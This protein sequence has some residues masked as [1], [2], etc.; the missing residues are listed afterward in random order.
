MFFFPAVLVLSCV[1][2]ASQICLVDRATVRCTIVYP[3]NP[4]ITEKFA[5]EELAKYLSKSTGQ[6]IQLYGENQLPGQLPPHLLVVGRCR[7]ATDAGIDCKS[8][9][10]EEILLVARNGNVYLA[11]GDSSPTANPRWPSEE[12]FGT[13]FSV[14]EFLERFLG[15]RW[16]WP[17]ELGEIV[18]S[19]PTVR[20]PSNLNIR[21]KPCFD[22]RYVYGYYADDPAITREQSSLWWRRQRVGSSKAGSPGTHSFNGWPARF[23]ETR[24]EYFAVG[25]DGTR[26][27]DAE[28]GGGHVCL[29]SDAVK[30]QIIEDALDWFSKGNMN[31]YIWPGDSFDLYGCKCPNCLAMEDKNAPQSGKHSRLVWSLVNEVA[32]EV[33]KVYPDRWIAGGSYATHADIPEGM[34]FEPNVSVTLC[35]GEGIVWNKKDIEE[36]R[37]RIED[38][39]K[40]VNSIYLWDYH[41]PAGPAMYIVYPRGI[42][43][44]W[45][46]MKGRVRGAIN[47]IDVGRAKYGGTW[48]EWP[49][50]VINMY[51]YMKSMWSPDFDPDRMVRQY[52]RDMFG[53]ASHPMERFYMYIQDVLDNNYSTDVRKDGKW[54]TYWTRLYTPEKVS[55]LMDF[56]DEAEKIAPAGTAYAKR[57]DVIKESFAPMADM[58]RQYSAMS[59]IETKEMLCPSISEGLKSF[60]G[61][62]D[63]GEWGKAGRTGHFSGSQMGAKVSVPTEALVMQDGTNLYVGWICGLKKGQK[64]KVECTLPTQTVWWDDNVELFLYG[65]DVSYQFILTAGGVLWDSLIKEGKHDTAW[66]SG[67]VVKTYVTDEF[68]TGEMAIPLKALDKLPEPL[69]YAN[70]HWKANFA[71]CYYMEGEDPSSGDGKVNWVEELHAW[72]PTLEG[73]FFNPD[74]NGIIK[75]P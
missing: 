46:W 60:D 20:V 49:M 51:V 65:N 29:T 26:R 67:A 14:Y 54:E 35:R 75:F 1:N 15:I 19:H 8:L 6:Q 7:F 70:V 48:P 18:P 12:S 39:H 30:K 11:G 17:G 59:R 72:V 33:G 16:Y 32:K 47:E 23:A 66:E 53:P 64:L 4:S 68:W 41:F 5:A 13:L 2:L 74:K 71:R 61:K 73:G 24:P 58:S 69:P 45:R 3:A 50:G 21:Q 56:L 37:R 36:Q 34:K 9:E 43:H 63:P 44:E 57:V 10:N 40:K 28:K 25:R 42:N 62:V 52:C 22:F 38:W 27:F 31:F 55:R